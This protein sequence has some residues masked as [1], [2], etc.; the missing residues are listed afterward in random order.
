MMK[1]LLPCLAGVVAVVVILLLGRNALASLAMTTGIQ[2]VTGLRAQIDHVEVGL[3][4]TSLRVVGLRVM[5]PGGFADPVMVSV[6]ELYVNY[7][8]GAF[9][10]GRVH[11]EAVRLHVDEFHVVRSAQNQLNLNALRPVQATQQEQ[12]GG[13]P[14]A[15]QSPMALQVDV[16]ELKIGR[17][18]YADYTRSAEGAH[19]TFE[20]GL[21]ERYEHITNPTA[22]VSLIV[23]KALAKTTIAQ[24]VNFDVGAL[25]GEA[26]DVL[27]RAT[28]LTTDALSQAVGTGTKLGEGAAK[29]AGNVVNDATSVL[30]NVLP[31]GDSNESKHTP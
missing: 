28:T 16:L 14:A 1:K 20:I 9:F 8:L 26:S 13:P 2:T 6:P 22:L 11:L 4:D 29:A 24:L 10:S 3:V 12:A 17:V 25:R 18:V 23:V 19:Q 27:K 21:H 30:K 5:N 15:Q 31:F 7:D